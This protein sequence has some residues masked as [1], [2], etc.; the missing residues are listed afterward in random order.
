MGNSVQNQN[1]RSGLKN[2]NELNLSLKN[3]KIESSNHVFFLRNT[4]LKLTIYVKPLQQRSFDILKLFTKLSCDPK[5]KNS[6]LEK[7]RDGVLHVLT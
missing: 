2:R 4:K 1:I 7:V 6:L 5:D 3:L